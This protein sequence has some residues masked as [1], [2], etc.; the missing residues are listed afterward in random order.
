M[1]DRTRQW[2]VQEFTLAAD[3]I[4]LCGTNIITLRMWKLCLALLQWSKGILSPVRVEESRLFESLPLSHETEEQAR[5][6]ANGLIQMRNTADSREGRL[7]G[8]FGETWS[9]LSIF[10]CSEPNDKVFA[11]LGMFLNGLDFPVDYRDNWRIIIFKVLQHFEVENALYLAHDMIR[12]SIRSGWDPHGLQAPEGWHV[13]NYTTKRFPV[14]MN[15]QSLFEHMSEFSPEQ[16]NINSE[17]VLYVCECAYCVDGQA[18]GRS[19]KLPHE[20]DSDIQ[21]QNDIFLAWCV[22]GHLSRRM[23]LLRETQTG[24]VFHAAVE[25]ID[26]LIRGGLQRS[27]QRYLVHRLDVPG[28]PDMAF[29]RSEAENAGNLT[30][31]VGPEVLENILFTYSNPEP[32]CR[33]HRDVD[34]LDQIRRIWPPLNKSVGESEPQAHDKLARILM[35]K[36]VRWGNVN[37]APKTQENRG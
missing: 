8:G 35:D 20:S 3:S 2:I 14:L 31:K 6:M 12:Y 1:H 10:E 26:S 17:I 18:R 19:R 23:F 28:L 15:V 13:K 16:K 7:V 27:E 5:A 22:A 33:R 24:Y 21:S 34:P 25:H 30:A 36:A 37:V 4:L 32:W 29:T 9:S 11:L